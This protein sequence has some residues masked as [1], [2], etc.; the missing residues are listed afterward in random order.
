MCLTA[1][2][3]DG[4]VDIE[5]PELNIGGWLES[6]G[7]FFAPKA[8]AATGWYYNYYFWINNNEVTVIQVKTSAQGDIAIPS[9]YDGYPVTQIS[10]SAFVGCK[11][12]TSI[13]IPDS[14]KTIGDCAFTNCENLESLII[15]AGVSDIGD[16]I[17]SNCPKL[18]SIVVDEKNSY[19]SSDENG[20]LF[21]KEKTELI[22]YPAANASTSYSIPDSVISIKNGAFSNDNIVEIIIGKG[23]TTI[24][25]NSF[26]YCYN[27]KNIIVAENNA[28]FSSDENGVLFNKDKTEL[29]FYAK[30]KKETIYKIPEGV[31]TI[32]ENA[33]H[34]VYSLRHLIISSSVVSIE[35]YAVRDNLLSIEVDTE[36]QYFSN[37]ENG[38]L[39]NKE[40]TKLIRYPVGSERTKYDIPYGVKEIGCI[41]FEGSHLTDITI[42]DSLQSIGDNAFMNCFKI[43]SI[44]IGDKVSTIGNGA[45]KF[46]DELS[47]VVIGKNVTIIGKSAF[48]YCSKL[49]N[50]TIGNNVGTIGDSAFLYC[51]S[52]TDITIPGS[53]ESIGNEAFSRS[54]LTNITIPDSVQCIGNEAFFNCSKLISV[55]IGDNVSTIG[56]YAFRYCRELSDVI[57]GNNVITIGD[58]A[59]SDCSALA[60]ITI[61]DSVISIGSYVFSECSNLVNVKMGNALK[62]IGAAAFANCNSIANITLP[63]SITLIGVSAFS[64]CSSLESIKI[65]N[66]LEEIF[67]DTFDNCTNLVEVEIG[68]G[69]KTIGS[70][71]FDNCTR[72]ESIVIGKNM[73]VIYNNAFNNCQMLENVYFV[74][75]EEKWNMIKIY[76]GNSA[77]TNAHREYFYGVSAG[78]NVEWEIDGDSLYIRGTGTSISDFESG[79]A[80]WYDYKDE[81]KQIYIFNS[82]IERI[83]Q[84]AF[85]GLENVEHI[86][87]SCMDLSYIGQYAFY[88]LDSMKR[89]VIFTGTESQWKKIEIGYG[90]D[91]L[92]RYGAHCTVT[93]TYIAGE[94]IKFESEPPMTGQTFIS[95]HVTI[96]S[97]ENFAENTEKLSFYKKA[98]FDGDVLTALK[99]WDVIGDIGKAVSF[100][101]DGYS[102]SANYFDIYLSELILALNNE[103]KTSTLEWKVANIYNKHY[104]LMM[105]LL[106]TSDEWEKSATPKIEKELEDA[107]KGKK[108]ELTEGTQQFLEAVFGDIYKNHKGGFSSVFEGLST[109]SS[110][111]DGIADAA[112]IANMFIKAYNTYVVS[113]AFYEVNDEFFDV[114]YDAAYSLQGLYGKEFIKSINKAKNSD[115]GKLERIYETMYSFTKDAIYFA[116]EKVLQGTIKTTVYPAVA[117]L[118]GCTAGN[119]GLATF[120]YNTTYKILDSALKLG[121][122]SEAYKTMNAIA[123]I[124]GRLQSIV[125]TYRSRLLSNQTEENAKRYD[126]A[127]NI[128]QQTNIYLYDTAYKYGSYN[129]NTAEMNTASL[130]KNSW[131]RLKCHYGYYGNEYSLFSVQCPVDVYIYDFDGVLITSIVNEEVVEYNSD[132]TVMNS[133]GHKTFVYPADRDYSIKIVA[134]EEGEMDYSVNKINSDGIAS[135]L[136]T[137]NVPLAQEQE[138]RVSVQEDNYKLSTNDTLIDFDYNSKKECTAHTFGEWIDGTDSKTRICTACGFKEFELDCKHKHTQIEVYSVVPDCTQAGHTVYVC[139]GCGEQTADG[140]DVDALG[141]DYEIDCVVEPTCTQ[142]GYTIYACVCGDSYTADYVKEKGHTK[143]TIKGYSASCTGTGLTDGAKCSVCDEVLVAQE[144][145]G[146]A[147]HTKE[148]I[149]GYSAT[150]TENGLSDG[151]KCGTCSE[152]FVAQQTVFAQGHSWGDWYVVDDSVKER[153]CSACSET[154]TT[155]LDCDCNCHS[156]SPFLQFFYKFA[157]FFWQ[158]FNMENKRIC[159]CGKAHW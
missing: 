25:E 54:G 77:L 39:F 81:I 134:R 2:P 99:T 3:L 50:I 49:A 97:D 19:Y 87:M 96:A 86:H 82:Y 35:D 52:L 28:N 43:T 4:F 32:K 157:R 51:S 115:L 104:K 150:C 158:L 131:S 16:D 8:R 33:F 103:E 126:M 31:K 139:P 69:V 17:F 27:L 143:E 65:P 29:V 116:Y 130:Y 48:A 95:E 22:Y 94:N 138:F 154:E 129:K 142:Q 46:C 68:K 83:G 91:V 37:D 84:Y 114:C 38:V 79:E 107:F 133:N 105:N 61:P 58:Y 100:Q 117:K 119:I 10:S 156:S 145:I 60:D 9:K 11:K 34:S 146:V 140:E 12:L 63:D 155:Q 18:K 80:P 45:F 55:T 30:G 98:V 148:T 92:K 67:V 23:L 141:H 64:S 102:F 24:G 41:A 109:T 137:Y 123:P 113:K 40:K 153:R 152:I 93:D 127:Y 124:E 56:N 42:P 14:V 59:F 75:S 159:N 5:L 121:K 36:N 120:A 144:V 85:Y 15:G 72:L 70:Y 110:I 57:I 7:E 132:I 128:L 88:G 125:A 122:K 21:N 53:V 147:G 89:N 151:V 112:N 62:T 118:L 20:V 108:F 74:G 136:S 78:E 13:T 101:L 71:A 73:S 76:G 106:K 44:T 1:A 90:N 135:E 111:I 6:V 149:K 26:S 47:N 66:S